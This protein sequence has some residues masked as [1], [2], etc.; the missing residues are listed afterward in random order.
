MGKLSHMIINVIEEGKCKGIK[1]GR[2][3]T[4]ITHFMFVDDLLLFRSAYEKQ[5][6][7][8]KDILY[9]LCFISGQ[10]YQLGKV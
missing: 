1:A 5:M 3:G 6:R 4:M 8:I 7:V 10:K 9:S 2:R